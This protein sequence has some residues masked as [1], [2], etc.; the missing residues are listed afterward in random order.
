MEISGAVQPSLDVEI[1]DMGVL[2]M[3]E[4]RVEDMLELD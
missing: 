1:H 3:I 4:I 2:K